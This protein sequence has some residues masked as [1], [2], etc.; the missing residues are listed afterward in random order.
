V[1]VIGDLVDEVVDAAL[2]EILKK[3]VGTG[4]R[5]LRR[6]RKA[7]ASRMPARRQR[8]RSVRARAKSRRRAG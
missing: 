5:A 6:K 8:K 1:S 2:R 7:P 3:T 4:K